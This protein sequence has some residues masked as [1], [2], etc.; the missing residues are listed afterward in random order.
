MSQGSHKT[1][2]GTMFPSMLVL[3]ADRTVSGKVF[4]CELKQVGG[5]SAWDRRVVAKPGRMGQLPGVP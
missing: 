2:N 4:S 3:E 1:C 5:M